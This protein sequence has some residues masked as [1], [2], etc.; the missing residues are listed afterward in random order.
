[1][2]QV[3]WRCFLKGGEIR[4]W[5]TEPVCS[6]SPGILPIVFLVVLIYDIV[7]ILSVLPEW[8]TVYL[9][10]LAQQKTM[11]PPGPKPLPFVGNILAF[12]RDQLGFLGSIQRTYGDTATIYMGN[13]PIVLLFGPEHVRYVLSE[14]PGNFTIQEIAGPLRQMVGD[15][16][17]T[18]DGDAHRQQRRLVQPAFSNK[19]IE[20]YAGVIV[21]YTQ[22]MLEGWKASEELDMSRAMQELTL[23]II[24]K[25]LFDVDLAGRVDEL[26]QAFTAMFGYP[27]GLLEA[28]FNIRIDRSFTAYGRR[29]AA[30]RKVDTFIYELIAQRRTEERDRGDLLSMLFAAQEG[31]GKLTGTQLHD[32]IMTFLAAGHG[33]TANA[34][35]WTFYLL[36]KCPEAREKLL[37]ELHAVLAGRVPTVDDMANLLYLEWV[38]NESLRLYPPVWRLMRRATGAFALDGT[39]FPAGTTVMLCQW[40]IHRLPEIWEYPD[41]FQPERWGPDNNQKIAQW[42][43]FPFGGGPRIC[44]GMPFALLEAKLLLATILQ[45]YTP[46][47]APDYQVELSPLITL[48]PKNGL[49]MI[50]APSV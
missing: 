3:N 8:R 25:C 7:E 32:Q 15:S 42:A 49:R 29:M 21:R 36:S 17:L 11:L 23:R 4:I 26:V 46:L 19:R 34:L 47:T 35:T 38:L 30:R 43:Y 28:L 41:S 13:M 2:Y 45:H 20:S 31:G 18:I 44:I 27:L 22:E 14:N 37:T 24:A 40:I 6:T 12:R 9:V 48:S 10:K 33:T 39:R 50:V 5:L 1:M 16:L